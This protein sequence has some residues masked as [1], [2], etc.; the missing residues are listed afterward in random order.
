MGMSETVNL[1]G[2]NSLELAGGVDAAG[3][4]RSP[5]RLMVG[6]LH[7]IHAYGESDESLSPLERPSV[8]RAP[9]RTRVFPVLLRRRVLPA[10]SA[11][12]PD[13]PSRLSAGAGR[14]RCR[15][16]AGDD[17]RG[18]HGDEGGDTGRIRA[19]DRQYHGSGENDLVSNRQPSA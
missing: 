2:S 14:N 4:P 7:L 6:L 17:D 1:F 10:V 8:V 11:V 15:G 16:V 18:G 19:R 13:Q 12:R 5:K 3:H 9:G